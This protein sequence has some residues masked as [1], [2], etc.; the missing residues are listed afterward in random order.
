M[1]SHY[2]QV[3]LDWMVTFATDL[4]IPIMMLT[5]F[6]GIALRGLIYYTIKREEWFAKEFDRRVDHHLEVPNVKDHLSFFVTTKRLL[7]KTYYEMFEVRALMKRRKPDA[8][9]HWS[10]RVFLVKQGTAW[11]VK[12]LL[13]HLRHLRYTKESRPKLMQISKNSF[14]RNPCFSRVFGILPASVFNDF[15][16]ILPG[17]FIVG[18]IFGTFLGIMK[19]LPDLGTMDL[20]D[21]EGT[22]LIMDQF[23]LKVSFSMS[24][25]LV[26][27]LLSVISSFVNTFFSPEKTF[28]ETVDRLES[29]LDKLWNISTNNDHPQDIPQFDE[30]RDPLDALAEQ[31]VDLEFNKAQRRSGIAGQQKSGNKAS[32]EAEVKHTG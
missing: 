19:A 18:G 14:Q 17:M 26:G 9:M 29:S 21:V 13:K 5:F 3:F 28:V 16:N 32:E 20:N 15:L 1:V 7:E 6:A 25:S 30:H 12:D 11:M 24:T 10:D 4:L 22:K 8:V 23:L 31:A 27:I 2:V